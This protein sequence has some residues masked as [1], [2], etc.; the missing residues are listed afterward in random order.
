MLDG[1]APAADD[2]GMVK[3]AIRRERISGP[4]LG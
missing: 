1:D 3:G 2:L 4:M